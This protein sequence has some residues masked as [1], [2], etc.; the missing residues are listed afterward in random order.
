MGDLPVT[1]WAICRYLDGRSADTLAGDLPNNCSAFGLVA[2]AGGDCVRSRCRREPGNAEACA[3]FDKPAG[4]QGGV[5]TIRPGEIA[6]DPVRRP[7]RG[8]P[9][10]GHLPARQQLIADQSAQLP[11]R[12]AASLRIVHIVAECPPAIRLPVIAWVSRVQRVI[13]ELPTVELSQLYVRQNVPG[14]GQVSRARG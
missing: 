5:P 6:E 13:A 1:R 9:G 7:V 12:I 14:I 4:D 11:S 8:V 2:I 10:I 3:V